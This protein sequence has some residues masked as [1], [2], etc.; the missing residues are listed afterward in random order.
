VVGL[1]LGGIHSEVCLLL[2]AGAR[3]QSHVRHD[4][5]PCG[6]DRGAVAFD[7]LPKNSLKIANETSLRHNDEGHKY[8]I[9]YFSA[10]TTRRPYDSYG[11]DVE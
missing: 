7:I 1:W 4:Y 8:Q 3:R 11:E 6:Y 9:K 2:F 10:Y 5:S